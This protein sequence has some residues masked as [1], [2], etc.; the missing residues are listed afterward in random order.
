VIAA[1]L[2]CVCAAD[3]YAFPAG[4]VR[5]YAWRLEQTVVQETL[6]DRLEHRTTMAWDLAWDG[7]GVRDGL[8]VAEVTVLAVRASH[9]GPGIAARI[10]TGAGT[11]LDDP[12]L[13]LLA[14]WH[15]ATMTVSIQPT[16][17]RVVAVTGADAVATAAQAAL[18]TRLRGEPS[19]ALAARTA[20]I[21]SDTALAGA[22]TCLLA[23]PGTLAPPPIAW[24]ATTGERRWTGP[25]YAWSAGPAT[26]ALA[27]DPALP[28]VAGVTELRGDGATAVPVDGWPAASQHR[29]AFRLT[30]DAA[31]QEVVQRH[32]IAWS[33]APAELR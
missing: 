16:T 29:A 18:R 25:A 17:G 28:W 15:L 30:I 24:S 6:D 23:L 1:V 10:D 22:W 7:A 19:P 8:A 3:G 26:M 12:L 20:G 2:L 9:S 27:T 33:F 14:A 31:G 13:G 21:L 4:E 32:S 11:G 5:T